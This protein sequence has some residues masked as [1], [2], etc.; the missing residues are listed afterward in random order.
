MFLEGVRDYFELRG[1]QGP[2]HYPVLHLYTYTLIYWMTDDVYNPYP[3]IIL[4]TVTHLLV[5]YLA[6]KIYQEAFG[7]NSRNVL[8][9]TICCLGTT[10]TAN[11]TKFAFWDSLNVMFIYLCI[12]MLQKGYSYLGFTFFY[13]ALAY[14]LNVLLYLPGIMF[15]VSLN[16]GVWVSIL[17]FLLW[18]VCH[19]ILALQFT[20]HNYQTYFTRAFS[21]A[22]KFSL[23]GS[24]GHFWIGKHE[25]HRFQEP[26]FALLFALAIFLN[27]LYVLIVRWAPLLHPERKFGLTIF[28]D[29]IGLIPCRKQSKIG[30]I[31]PYFV[32]EVMFLSNL[33]GIVWARTVHRQF[34]I[35]YWFSIP[36][37]AY[38]SIITN[39]I[40]LSTVIMSMIMLNGSY[41]ISIN[42]LDSI[43]TFSMNLFY[44]VLNVF[45][46]TPGTISK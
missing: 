6:V 45:G 21:I 28:L 40:L 10:T 13:I 4:A 37:L 19:F 32:A 33:I 27:L 26:W 1:I 31:S 43:V 14:K 36:F 16:K 39:R 29:S 2:W 7:K 34:M 24:I 25:R 17:C 12:Y 22:K 41:I 42:E 30:K 3:A 8:L 23:T 9:V 20:I 46:S 38:S 11:A 44:L 15:I 35:W 5:A 18:I